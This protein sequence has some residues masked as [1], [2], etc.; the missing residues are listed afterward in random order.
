ML[1]CD[2]S[3][4]NSKLSV[5]KKLHEFQYI[6]LVSFNRIARKRFLQLHVGPESCYVRFPTHA[7]K[8]TYSRLYFVTNAIIL[9]Y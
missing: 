4:R 1:C 7:F 5:L 2:L 9:Q 8:I 3:G 6:M